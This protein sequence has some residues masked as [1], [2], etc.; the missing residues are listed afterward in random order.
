[1][2]APEPT[3]RSL[4]L[5]SPL[6]TIC[7]RTTNTIVELLVIRL[8]VSPSLEE[9][10]PGSNLYIHSFTSSFTFTSP[11]TSSFARS[12]AHQFHCFAHARDP[13]SNTHLA[14]CLEVGSALRVLESRRPVKT[15][16]RSMCIEGCS[17][18][19]SSRPPQRVS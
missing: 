5:S 18:G 13:N 15:Q 1:M 16:D 4:I 8:P 19:S 10:D 7:S 11:L 9:L 2:V 12:L 17:E 14:R 6:L 3:H